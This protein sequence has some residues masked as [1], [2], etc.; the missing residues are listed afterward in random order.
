ML[1]IT[2]GLIEYDCIILAAGS[3]RR[4]GQAKQLLTYQ[5][6]PL[7]LATVKNAL[8]SFRKVILVQGAV[9]L[10][11]C[12]SELNGRDRLKVVLNPD[13]SDG[14]LGSLQKGIQASESH[15]I[16]VLLADLPLVKT[17]T[18]TELSKY[19]HQH[20][21]IYP[22]HNNKRGHPV[23]F[24]K[25]AKKLLM[26]ASAD[27]KAMHVVAE[28]QPFA[29]EVDDSGIYTDIDRPEDYMKLSRIIS[30]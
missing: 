8:L 7:F 16:F 21:V 23:V 11:P 22:R 30:D 13:Y 25:E 9:D 17:K 1:Q 4:M 26:N 14:Q 27:K 2:M 20:K 28:L 24:G 6:E 15:I 12:V 19:A 3:S 5:G 29:V 18:F 10:S